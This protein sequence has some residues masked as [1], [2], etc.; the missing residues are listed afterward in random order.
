MSA[1]L[2]VLYGC[3]MWICI[4][5]FLRQTC[6]DRKSKAVTHSIFKKVCCAVLSESGDSVQSYYTLREQYF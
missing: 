1:A 5:I 6:R 3:Q 2:P 4:D